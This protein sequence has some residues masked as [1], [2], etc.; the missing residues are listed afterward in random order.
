[1]SHAEG[2]NAIAGFFDLILVPACD[3]TKVIWHSK[4]CSWQAND[5]L[6][7]DQELA[8]LDVVLEPGEPAH[9]KAD[10]HVH[11]TLRLGIGDS[12]DILEGFSGHVDIGLE[13]SIGLLI[14][15][16]GCGFKDGG[17]C[18]LDERIGTE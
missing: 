3:D 9:I 1:M 4:D 5:G 14:E 18:L 6:L 2:F 10:H 8:E 16:C 13:L 15:G 7:R 17:Q 11:G 12:R